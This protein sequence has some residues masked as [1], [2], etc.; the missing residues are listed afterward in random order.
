MGDVYITENQ[1]RVPACLD[2]RSSK[3]EGKY[4]ITIWHI[5]LENDNYY[6]NYG[7]YANGFLVETCS[8]Q[9]LMELSDMDII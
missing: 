6:R 3:Y 4:P 2:E 1:Y 8:I 5:A 7:L 9:Y